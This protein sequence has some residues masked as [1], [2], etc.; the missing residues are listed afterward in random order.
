MRF[1]PELGPQESVLPPDDNVE[2]LDSGDP[3]NGSAPDFPV[4]LRADSADSDVVIEEP[5]TLEPDTLPPVAIRLKDLPPLNI[6]ESQPARVPTLLDRLAPLGPA[7]SSPVPLPFPAPAAMIGSW[8]DLFHGGEPDL[9]DSMV[10]DTID[11]VEPIE[12]IEPMDPEPMLE[13]KSNGTPTFDIDVVAE[14]TP[15]SGTAPLN[16]IEMSEPIEMIDPIDSIEPMEL[17]PIATVAS[18]ELFPP[19][20]EP[21]QS[22]PDELKWNMALAEAAAEAMAD[23]ELSFDTAPATDDV[24]PPALAAPTPAAIV[25]EVKETDAQRLRKSL[26]AFIAGEDLDPE[27]TKLAMRA[28]AAVLLEQGL[29]DEPKLDRALASLKGNQKT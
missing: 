25:M 2:V 19:P 26:L 15:F 17:E 5:A 22:A 28:I 4:P 16:P 18:A 13:A 29:L 1:A 24:V 6:E 10:L 20:L 9:K 11:T 12:P 3:I 23:A 27:T 14:G 7:A 8:G 21:S